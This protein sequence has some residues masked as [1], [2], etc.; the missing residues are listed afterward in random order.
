[1]TSLRILIVDD[2]AILREG[3]KTILTQVGHHQV[4]GEASNAPEAMEVLRRKRVDFVLL[5]V[6]LPGRS[7]I[8][9]LKQIK[10]EFPAI[11][12]LVLSSHPEDQY[13]LRVVKQGAAG[14]LTKE[15]APELLLTAIGKVVSDGRYITATLAAK[16]FD[17]VGG[18]HTEAPHQKLSDREF[19]IFKLI[20]LGNGLTDIAARLHVSVKTV[21]THRTRILEKT[22]FTSNADMTRYALERG[23][24]E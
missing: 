24:I 19:E 4:A 22:G 8:D 17:E 21:S 16:L 3:L 18:V 1:M 20:A 6:S 11:P 10:Q 15:S 13:A 2:H 14:Y 7:G 23:L 9:L 12:V 5:D